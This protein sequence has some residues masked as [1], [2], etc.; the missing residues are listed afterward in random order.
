MDQEQAS[1]KDKAA[2]TERD[3][4]GMARA[5]ELLGETWT[6]LIIREILFGVTRFDQIHDNLELPR[7]VLSKRLRRLVDA[8]VLRKRT[9]REAGQRPR[10]QYV[11]TPAGVD[12]A[13]PMIALMH[14]GS[15]HLV[16]GAASGEIV[17]RTSGE[18]LSIGAVDPKGGAV[19]LP[20]IEFRRRA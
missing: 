13:L 11:L 9:Y 18:K 8:G 19:A 12:L 16:H 20:E 1:L 14:W 10:Q 17:R 3:G 2:R 7:S 5:A 15:K 6:L 4:C